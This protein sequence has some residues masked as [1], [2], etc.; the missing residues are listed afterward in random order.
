MAELW[1]MPRLKSGFVWTKGS[2]VHL[3][4][5]IYGIPERS[6]ALLSE[7]DC[8]LDPVDLISDGALSI[9]VLFRDEILMV[10]NAI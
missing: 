5:R 3:F 9:Y 8:V 6:G 2:A 10:G 1:I 4:E 7:G